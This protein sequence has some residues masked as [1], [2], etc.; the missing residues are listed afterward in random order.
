MTR[1]RLEWLALAAIPIVALFALL[2]LNA[3][4]AQSLQSENVSRPLSISPADIDALNAPIL[5]EAEARGA[6]SPYVDPK[7]I[8]LPIDTLRKLALEE[9][10]A[11]GLRG[12]PASQEE[13]YMT[14]GQHYAGRYISPEAVPD[15]SVPV[16]VAHYRGPVD[17]PDVP[18]ANYIQI[19]LDTV[20][21]D[22]IRTRHGPSGGQTVD[23]FVKDP[24]NRDLSPQLALTPQ[25]PLPVPPP[26]G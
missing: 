4:V 21:G 6:L 22:V 24:G 15:R 11:I 20:T 1:Q 14:Y 10:R 8:D 18:N 13:F 5:R 23:V 26:T 3:Q 12:E 25:A 2:H 19:V 9:A 17:D 16:F 7:R